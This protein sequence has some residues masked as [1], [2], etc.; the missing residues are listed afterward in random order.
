MA[1]TAMIAT[2]IVDS[3][4]VFLELDGMFA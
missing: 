1:G 3:K 2:M 4:E